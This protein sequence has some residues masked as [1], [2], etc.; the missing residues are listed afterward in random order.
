MRPSL[1]GAPGSD[2]SVQGPELRGRLAEF[3]GEEVSP[4]TKECKLR[5]SIVEKGIIPLQQ[6]AADGIATYSVSLE[7]S[8]NMEAQTF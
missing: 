6:Y 1:R 7:R 2:A 3:I 8:P 4:F 5:N